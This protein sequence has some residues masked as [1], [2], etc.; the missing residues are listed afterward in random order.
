MH[1]IKKQ[2]VKQTFFATSLDKLLDVLIKTLFNFYA[3]IV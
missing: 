2:H 1:R 3:H